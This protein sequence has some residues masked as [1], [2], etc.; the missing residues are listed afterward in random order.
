M[1]NSDK[2]LLLQ[3]FW[4]ENRQEKYDLISSVMY[5]AFILKEDKSKYDKIA[6][7]INSRLWEYGVTLVNFSYSLCLHLF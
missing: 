7:I 1:F 4:D 5:V 3:D 6:T 2:W